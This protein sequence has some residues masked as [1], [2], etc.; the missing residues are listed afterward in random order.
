[1]AKKG[2]STFVKTL[3]WEH[4]ADFV[5]FQ[6]T[7]KSKY[8]MS[9][10]L[11]KLILN[12]FLSGGGFHPGVDLEEFYLDLKKER[13]DILSSDV[14]TYSITAKVFDKKM[15]KNICLVSVYGPAQDEGKEAFLTEL[16][17]ICFKNKEPM[18]IGG[19]FNIL[20]FSE[21]KNKAFCPQQVH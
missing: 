3:L 17:H 19:D 21:D 7:I 5:G 2:M 14:G 20:R 9:F 4:H 6:E 18:L 16:A 15:R 10:F 12:R 8:P 13:F 11:E 1:V